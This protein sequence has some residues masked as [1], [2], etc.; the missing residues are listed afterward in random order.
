MVDVVQVLCQTK[1]DLDTSVCDVQ[2]SDV[3]L[4]WHRTVAKLKKKVVP[5]RLPSFTSVP[6]SPSLHPP[7]QCVQN[8]KYRRHY[9]WLKIAEAKKQKKSRSTSHQT[10]RTISIQSSSPPCAAVL[11]VIMHKTEK[12]NR[13]I[14]PKARKYKLFLF[15]YSD[16]A[17]IIRSITFSGPPTPHAAHN[18]L[19]FVLFVCW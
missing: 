10:P 7:N 13:K 6:H 19:V 2:S 3:W 11:P 15:L 16:S 5:S 17:R 8:H 4:C 1:I 18:I 9:I 14:F 12:E